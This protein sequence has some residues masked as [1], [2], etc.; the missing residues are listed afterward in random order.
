VAL[1]NKGTYVCGPSVTLPGAGTYLLVGAVEVQVHPSGAA[2][3]HV[4]ARLAQDS[5]PPTTS[6]TVAA[7][8][9]TTFNKGGSAG[10]TASISVVAIVT[11]SGSAT[12]VI[13]AAADS[14]AANE[15]WILGSAKYNSTPSG[16]TQLTAVKIA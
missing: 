13:E 5:C 12:Y 1:G 6:P 2:D 16:A 14:G 7:A 11:T 9:E 8:G 10:E 4:T 3:L 15:Q